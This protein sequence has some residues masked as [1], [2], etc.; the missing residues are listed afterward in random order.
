MATDGKLH[1]IFATDKMLA[2]LGSQSY[3]FADGTFKVAPKVFHQLYVL[4]AGWQKTEIT[5]PC[6]FVLMSRRKEIDY[7]AVYE[8]VKVCFINHF[9]FLNLTFLASL[10]QCYSEVSHYRF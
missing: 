6:V 10:Q 5:L 9:Q 4:H 7:K 1:H 8:W 3:W 2:M